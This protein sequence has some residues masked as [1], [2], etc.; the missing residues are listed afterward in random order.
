MRARRADV[1][2]TALVAI[3][4]CAA[5][6]ARVP[7]PGSLTAVLGLLLFAAPGYLW[8]EALLGDPVAGLERISVATGLSLCVPIFGGLAL[9][10]AGVPLHRTAW[11]GLLAGVTLAGDVGVLIRRGGLTPPAPDRT[12]QR[13]AMPG[14]SVAALAVALLLA[15]GGIAIARIG[16]Q[17]QQDPGFTQLWLATAPSSADIASLGVGNFE[18]RTVRYRLVLLHNG[19][20]TSAWDLTL[21]NGQRWQRLQLLAGGSTTTADLYRLPDLV[22]PYRQVWLAVSVPAQS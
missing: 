11:L 7:A 17:R 20:P 3:L 6:L 1:P 2:I 4:A 16:A 18:G 9:Y 19:L 5:A 8:V 13:R 10:G 14:R 21:A 15:A 22:R 12:P